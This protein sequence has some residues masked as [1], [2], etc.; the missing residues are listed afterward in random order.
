MTPKQFCKKYNDE[1]WDLNELV[2]AA[3]DVDGEV[4]E[5]AIALRKAL[6][7]FEAALRKIKYSHG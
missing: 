6:D 3:S 1:P 7:E 4:G 2:S 5:K